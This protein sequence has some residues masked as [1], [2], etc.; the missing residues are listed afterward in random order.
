MV[1][2]MLLNSKAPENFNGKALYLL[3]T[4]LIESL[5]RTHLSVCYIFIWI[6]HKDSNMTPYEFWKKRAPRIGYLNV[7]GCLAKVVIPETKKR[8]F[9]PKIV[10]VVFIRYALYNNTNKFLVTNSETSQISNNTIIEAGDAIYF[11]NI[12]PFKTRIFS[13]FPSSNF[14]P[15][16]CTPSSGN[17]LS[18]DP[19][20]EVETRRNR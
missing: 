4:F 1:N 12:F 5:T 20:I 17:H 3:V 13:V 10:D 18:L 2:A 15:S 11:E 9:G 16:N 7:W 19:S 8:K 14:I 6:P